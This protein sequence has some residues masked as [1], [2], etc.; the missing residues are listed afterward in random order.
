MVQWHAAVEAVGGGV[1][2]GAETHPGGDEAAAGVQFGP[3]GD[4]GFGEAGCAGGVD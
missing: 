3:G 2:G 1:G 4:G